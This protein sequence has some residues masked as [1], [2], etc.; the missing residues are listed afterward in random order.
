M[1]AIIPLTLGFLFGAS[2]DIVGDL[3]SG[4]SALLIGLIVVIILT[5]Y[6]LKL[7]PLA[8]TKREKQAKL[9]TATVVDQVASGGGSGTL[10]P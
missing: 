1:G 10:L 3:L 7:L 4:I 6:L 9:P 5:F 2:L 8:A